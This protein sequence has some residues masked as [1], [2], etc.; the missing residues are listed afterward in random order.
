MR[1]F[2]VTNFIYDIETYH[3]STSLDTVIDLYRELSDGTLE[4]LDHVDEEGYESGEYTGLDFPLS[5]WYWAR[6]T[7]YSAG[8]NTVGAYEFSV[9]IP[10]A[11]GLCTLIVLGVDGVYSSALPTGTTVT[12][13][14]CGTKPFSG[15]KTVTYT[16]LTNG[17]YLVTL[18]LPSDFI[19]REDPNT[20]NQVQSLT[21]IFYAN[22]R[23]VAISGSWWLAG[24]EL[25][26]SV[27]VTSGVVRDAWTH[28]FLGNAQIA[29][30]A[31]SG[32]LTGAVVDGSV[33]LT[34]YRTNWLSSADGRL[35]P[36]IT[37]GSCNWNLSVNLPGYQPYTL[38]GAVSNLQTGAR[39]ALGTAFLV[40]TD[41]NANEVSDAWEALYFPGG[42][43]PGA[44]SDG[45][46]LDNRSEYLS[47]T[48]PTNALSVLRF[49]GAQAGTNAASLTWS[50]T[51]GRS[52]Q[53]LSVTSLVALAAAQT[54]GPWEAAHD[55]TSMAWSDT[56]APLHK[57]RFYRV[58]LNNP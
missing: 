58:R 23:R 39:M 33:I 1:F 6:I 19:P 38:P 42:M 5:G 17:S 28:A 14:G 48:D 15:S 52:Y 55:Q 31:A 26:S 21:N 9:D 16:G 40:P 51:S 10:A 37:L 53:L 57:T 2:L 20:P 34:S 44:D 32:S 13:D 35:P 41:T 25:L 45:D 22:P 7:P 12:V 18:P 3:L 11:D 54:N 47:G 56:N 50:V 46:G 8:T 36:D 4:A 49:L 24:F 27:A 30:T 43:S 29:F